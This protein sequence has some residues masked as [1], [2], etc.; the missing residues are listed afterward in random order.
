MDML[1]D[2]FGKSK[3]VTVKKGDKEKSEEKENKKNEE[4]DKLWT[5]CPECKEIIFNKKLVEKLMVCPKCDYHMRLTAT[6]RLHITIDE[7]SFEEFASDIQTE[8][9]LN[10]PGYEEKHN[11]YRVKTGLD[12]AV[13]VGEAS[14]NGFEIVIGVMDF[15]F[16]GGS[17]GSVVGEKITRAVERAIE[18]DK[19][20]IIFSTAGGARMQE[21]MLSLMQMAKTSAAIKKLNQ[22]GILYVSVLT[23]PTSGG[24]T[25]SFAS[26][27]DIIMAEPGALI[28]F[29]GPRVIKQ[30][31]SEELPEGFQRSEFLHEHGMVDMVIERGSLKEELG[32]ILKI[33]QAGVRNYVR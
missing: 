24:V 8:D 2:W 9:A 25:A 26:L 6:D 13:V 27:G 21:G 7:D 32:R 23:D 22:A 17:M 29:A 20:L 1:K 5:K 18:T 19:P 10:F 33:H 4:N 11:K 28:A 16:M 15:H 3:Y 30:T 12:E 14:I 31:I